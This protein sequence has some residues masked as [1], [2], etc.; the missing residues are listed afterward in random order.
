MLSAEPPPQVY[1]GTLRLGQATPSFDAETEPSEEQ[2]WEHLTDADL[3][4]AAEKL[5]GD[6]L[7]LPPMFSAIKIKG[8]CLTLLP[9]EPP[10]VPVPW[11]LSAVGWTTIAPY[12]LITH[13]IL[14]PLSTRAPS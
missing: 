2:P 11:I 6:I 10:H 3:R 7:Q 12:T 14:C 9:P 8:A 4:E 13:L 1:S 5:K